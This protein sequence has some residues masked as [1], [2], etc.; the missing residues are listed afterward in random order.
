MTHR[1]VLPAPSQQQLSHASYSH[2]AQTE[3]HNCTRASLD[4]VKL[5]I[6]HVYAQDTQPLGSSHASVSHNFS[7]PARI[8]TTITLLS[9]FNQKVFF[10]FNV[11]NNIDNSNFKQAQTIY[12]N[13]T[14][15]FCDRFIFHHLAPS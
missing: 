12:K 10:E 5:L 4:V 13:I 14:P 15:T 8:Q 9:I 11:Y 2:T 3:T 7:L 1:V 6:T